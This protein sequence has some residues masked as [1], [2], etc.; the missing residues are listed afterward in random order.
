MKVVITHRAYVGQQSWW[1]QLGE[2]TRTKIFQ[3]SPSQSNPGKTDRYIQ[4][5]KHTSYQY[6]WNFAIRPTGQKNG[7]ILY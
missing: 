6:C 1:G 5:Q 7:S 2:G 3:L 4:S